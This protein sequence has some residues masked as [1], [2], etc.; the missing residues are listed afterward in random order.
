MKGIE[1]SLVSEHHHLVLNH[2]AG[3]KTICKSKDIFYFIDSEFYKN[4]SRV[5]VHTPKRTIKVWDVKL[6]K[7][8]Q[9]AEIF[10]VLPD[11]WSKKW[12]SQSQLTKVCKHFRAWLQIDGQ[13]NLFLCKIN[14]FSPVDEAAPWNNLEVVEV[15]IDHDDDLYVRKVSSTVLFSKRIKEDL[16]RVIVPSVHKKK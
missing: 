9:I 6:D 11:F 13:P 5:G 1:S 8:C 14:E 12:L 7:G 16:F 15:C 4:P 2:L 3:K 10:N